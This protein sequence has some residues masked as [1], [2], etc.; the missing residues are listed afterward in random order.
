M[1]GSGAKELDR[2]RATAW[3]R[4]PK[5]PIEVRLRAAI[6]PKQTDIGIPPYFTIARYTD[7]S[8]CVTWDF[9]QDGM[10]ER[11]YEAVTV[12]H[13]VA[14]LSQR[15]RTASGMGEAAQKLLD[16]GKITW[17][18]DGRVA[19]IE[20]YSGP[21]EKTGL[22]IAPS[23]VPGGDPRVFGGSQP[24]EQQ[25]R[26]G[27]GACDLIEKTTAAVRASPRVAAAELLHTYPWGLYSMS[28]QE[29][30]VFVVRK[31]GDAGTPAEFETDLRQLIAGSY[32]GGIPP[33]RVFL[34]DSLPASP[35]FEAIWELY[36]EAVQPEP[37][38]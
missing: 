10:P 19:T 25:L 17:S 5:F 28:Q 26:C 20:G 1:C 4:S 35:G 27:P 32:E 33:V 13:L 34:K 7:Y 29:L 23:R 16:L 3:S 36:A 38:R 21:G 2:E 14:D 37:A 30:A 11:T 31:P 8:P 9:R 24:L 6:Y 18:P 22:L 12:S 15:P